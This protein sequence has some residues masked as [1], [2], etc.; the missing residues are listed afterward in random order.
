MTLSECRSKSQF[1]VFEKW[2]QKNSDDQLT[3]I[4]IETV[5]T[6]LNFLLKKVSQGHM[7][8]N[9][10]RDVRPMVLI[11]ILGRKYF[12]VRTRR[13]AD[14]KDPNGYWLCKDDTCMK[15]CKRKSGSKNAVLS[16]SF[17]SSSD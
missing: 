16:G 10:G 2:D 3:L 14:G 17:W 5:S 7:D 13:Y 12:T 1:N 8:D 11:L 4:F 9:L 15:F 6:I